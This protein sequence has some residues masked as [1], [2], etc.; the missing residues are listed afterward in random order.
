MICLPFLA[1][2]ICS[3]EP[4]VAQEICRIEVVEK[5][6]GWPVPLIELRTTNAL[7]FVTDNAGIIALAEPSLMNREVWFEVIGHGYGVPADGFGY[8]GI[9]LTLL[10]GRSHRVEVQRTSLAKRIGRLTGE[11]LFAESQKLNE[12]QSWRDG[13]VFGCDSVQNA[14]YRNQMFWAWGDTSVSSYPLGIFDMT[15]ARTSAQPF[16]QVRPPLYPRFEYFVDSKQKLRPIAKMP[17]TGPTW[18]TGVVS[19]LDRGNEERLVAFYRKIKPPLDVYEAGLCEWNQ[20]TQSFEHLTT[21]WQKSSGEQRHALLEDGHPSVWSDENG[22]RWLLFGNPFPRVRVRATYEAWKDVTAWQSIQAQTAVASADDGAMIEPHS[23]S[24]AWNEYR[25]RWVTVFLQRFGK[26]SAFGTL[27]YAEADKPTGPWGPA[28]KILSH[29][30]YTFYNPR[31]H[32]EFT[33][34]ADTIL[35]FEGTYTAEFADHAL[36]TPRYNYNQI[37]YRLDLDEPAFRPAH[38]NP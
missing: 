15:G 2:Q 28:V 22:E 10:P 33:R 30:N 9:R 23:G 32:A 38:T 25:K 35:L 27:W 3:D 29:E 11:G 12:Q 36:P 6:S 8:R 7:R 16:E 13:P 1:L 31:L 17:G 26:P 5:G 37:L 34:G 4:R 24:I 14:T 18:L 21:V 20:E 19:V